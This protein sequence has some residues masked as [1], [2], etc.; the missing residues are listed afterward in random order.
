VAA[1]A[2]QSKDGFSPAEQCTSCRA[3]GPKRSG[4]RGEALFKRQPN[5]NR[6]GH[7]D[8]LV[9]TPVKPSA[10]KAGWAEPE[11]AAVSST[12]AIR[13]S[14]R[15]TTD[16]RLMAKP[17]DLGSGED[18][19]IGDINTAGRA[20]NGIA[21]RAFRGVPGEIAVEM[22][23]T[24]KVAT[25][26]LILGD[27]GSGKSSI[28]DAL[29]F[30]LQCEIRG[31]RGTSA[32]PYARSRATQEL[33]EVRIALSDGEEV[34]RRVW[35]EEREGREPR[36][37]VDG[38]AIAGFSKT[39]LV[40]R[41]ADI[42]RFWETP[43]DQRQLVFLRYFRPGS[44]ANLELP[45]ERIE[46]LRG[47]KARATAARREAVRALAGVANVPPGD[48]PLDAEGFNRWVNERFYG[49]F[50][51]EAGRLRAQRRLSPPRWAALE[52]VR[53]TIKKVRRIEREIVAATSESPRGEEQE[54]TRVL[55]GVNE[56]LTDAFRAISPRSPVDMIR[57]ELGESSSVALDLV[58]RLSNGEEGSADDL[59]SEANRD[60]LAL[61]V[62]VTVAQA[63]AELGQARV[64]VLDDVFQSVD[65]PIRVAT[66]DYLLDR[67]DGWQ[68]V[69]TAHDRLWREQLTTLLR[70]HA[71]PLKSIEIVR[72]TFDDGPVIR[73][74]SGDLTAG[75]RAALHEGEPASIAMHAGRLLEQIADTLS[76]TLPISVVRRPGD[77]YTLG[78]VWPGVLKVLKK[79]NAST[80]A[81][82]VDRFMHL[83]NVLGMHVNWWA[84]SLSREEVER[85]GSAVLS[86]LEFVRCSTC[87]RWVE[88]APPNQLWM[89]RCGST[90]LERA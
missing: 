44:G 58:V 87:I 82:E 27:N 74:A 66:M 85:F 35:W 34:V 24:G 71:K 46:R 38:A 55:T 51:R 13:R 90:R 86:L 61:L 41:R 49:G 2:S 43:T 36:W 28:V 54:L 64:M 31:D 45:H 77:R 9:R 63:A 52:E 29:Q 68:F 89:C 70:R 32:L 18:E 40:L 72:W 12:R 20:V 33:P 50:D 5:W 7:G 11:L 39:P 1:V 81:E 60:L 83:R 62:F 4:S 73:A 6:G 42:L 8:Q 56:R 59:L 75:V 10:P 47:E 79:T 48:I 14:I 37:R 57:M 19:D 26:L 53:K 22:A 3:C 17:T 88:K 23:P 25:S 80:L 78:D 16:L 69:I 84:E 30:G 67:L 15:R 65:A 76:W 21:L